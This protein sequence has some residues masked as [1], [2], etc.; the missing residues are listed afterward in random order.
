MKK[1][2][3][4]FQYI[5]NL[6]SDILVEAKMKTLDPIRH[7]S[8]GILNELRKEFGINVVRDPAW[9]EFVTKV[10]PGKDMNRYHYFV[11]FKS[12]DDQKFHAANAYGRIGYKA[13][14]K[15]LGTF[16]DKNKAM[17]AAK[18]KLNA[19]KKKGY[20]TTKLS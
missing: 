19:K 11:V 3:N 18:T 2:L 15:D 13:R 14:V 12:D 8:R 6:A 5:E 16:D 7:H 17:N 10:D 4:K 1:K 20:E 9:R